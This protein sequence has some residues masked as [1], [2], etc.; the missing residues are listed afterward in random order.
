M[1]RTGEGT[2]DRRDV[3]RKNRGRRGIAS[4]PLIRGADSNTR[5][6]PDTFQAD[7]CERQNGPKVLTVM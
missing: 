7:E 1:L 3:E 6:P 4:S 5:C 2:G